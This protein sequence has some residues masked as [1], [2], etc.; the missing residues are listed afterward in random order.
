MSLRKKLDECLKQRAAD[1]ERLAHLDLALGDCTQQLQFVRE[2]QEKRIH[3][4][5]VKVSREFERS[6]LVLEERL[7]ET[8]KR[9]AKTVLENNHLSNSLLLKE[10]SIEDLSK[11]RAQVESELSAVMNRLDSME[12]NNASLK[13]EI[14]VLEKELDIRNEEREFNRRSAEV[15]QKQ[16]LESGKKVAKLEAECQRLRLLVRKRLPGPT[17]VTRMRKEAEVLTRDPSMKRIGALAEQLTSMEEENRT[18]KEALER[19]SNELQVSRNMY[20]RAASK[21]SQAV[22]T[23]TVNNLNHAPSLA[24]VSDMGS[25]DRASCAESWASALI[26]ELENFRN[27]KLKESA[28]SAK[29]RDSEINLMEDFVQMERIAVFSTDEPSHD[30][31]SNFSGPTDT[32]NSPLPL[33]GD[34]E[35][36]T[37]PLDSLVHELPDWVHDIAKLAV[38][39][40]RVNGRDPKEILEDIKSVLESD[41]KNHPSAIG[42]PRESMSKSMSKV[43]ELLE[44]IT[45]SSSHESY[46]S[47]GILPKKDENSPSKSSEMPTGYAVRVFQWKS[48]E[49][50]NTLQEF[51]HTCYDLLSE[52]ADFAKFLQELAFALEWILNHCF[53]IQD[54][55]S[56]REELARSLECDDPRS[57]I[58]SDAG[59]ICRN[60]ESDRSVTQ[61]ADGEQKEDEVSNKAPRR[62]AKSLRSEIE[63]L[64][65]SKKVTED[66]VESHKSNNEALDRQ[67]SAARVE[68]D[69]TEKRLSSLEVKLG[70]K[71]SCCEELENTCLNLQLQ[72]ERCQ[73]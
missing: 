72:L 21:L 4:A 40:N 57:E 53:S 42:G 36:K 62:T 2:E 32:I 55:S 73:K 69:E 56:M 27:E 10:K 9:L 63:S 41:R 30:C 46:N 65:E 20:A 64:R 29:A 47:S 1:E 6:R 48:S 59:S 23:R 61:P 68:P 12:K 70:N 5:V 18:L 50:S 51:L 19:K 44:G 16:H 35:E 54:V 52:R 7:E 14:R 8:T 39:E 37:D 3:D 28:V 38:K 66:Q 15:S 60:F 17:T 13:Y 34:I 33:T 22:P 71:N 58:E 31:L 49:L 67:L 24:S 43:I 11:Q 45:L 26:S 25:D